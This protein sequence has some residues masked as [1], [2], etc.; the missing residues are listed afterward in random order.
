MNLKFIGFQHLIYD[1]FLSYLSKVIDVKT[2]YII[3]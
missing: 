1:Y 3:Y 2:I